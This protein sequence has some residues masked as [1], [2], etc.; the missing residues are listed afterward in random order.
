MKKNGAEI[1]MECLREMGTDTIFGYPGGAVIP[2]YD[3]LY[4]YMDKFK[5]IA[6]SHEQGA[7]HAADGYARSSGKTGVVFATSGPGATN[8]VT[9]IATAYAD[10]VPLIVITGQVNRS[11]I[12]RDSFQEADIT[13][14]TLPVTKHNY[15][16]RRAEDIA[17]VMRE[18]F[19]IA[20]NKRKGPVLIDIPKDVF[21]EE[22]FYENQCHENNKY[23]KN[24]SVS[25]SENDLKACAELINHSKRPV[26]YCGGGITASGASPELME[27]CNKTGIPVVST[28]MGL[29]GFPASHPLSYG[30]V[31]MHG[32]FQA[33]MAVSSSDLILAAGA[34]FSDRVTG[35]TDS[36]AS[37]AKIIQ[38]DIDQAEIGKNKDV[39]LYILG[40]IKDILSKL[41]S[42]TKHANRNGWTKEI[43]SWKISQPYED[44][45]TGVKIIKK[46]NEILG[47]GTIVATDTGQHQMWTAQHWKFEKP[48]TLLSSG[49]FGT[50]GYGLGAAIG[51]SIANP[52]KRVL[53][54]TS[55]GS[56]RMNMNE[57]ATVSRNKLPITILLL[58]N[59]SLGM[60]RQWQNLFCEKRFSG[61]DLGDE[62]DYVKLANAFGITGRRIYCEDELDAAL[63]IAKS[64]STASLI[65]C[66]IDKDEMVLPIV[67]PGMG[68]NNMITK[69]PH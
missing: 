57:L 54:V 25:Y 27:L 31:G 45:M 10:S 39:D 4:K 43:D 61:T 50:M 59:H 64:G 17:S 14:I 55:D 68:I 48:G 19:R 42:Y 22:T 5:Y 34:R 9:G 15:L 16:V 47:S 21:T 26:L 1:V 32:F 51:A 18:A 69:M 58:N 36:F 60:V 11:L 65:E 29:G 37:R 67:P 23:S 6:T 41:N 40:D 38:I 66:V 12:G 30:L 7:V 33:N 24:I 3:A 52:G 20:N 53:L 8:T 49:G 62:V 56:F 35:S 46:A 44:G 28:M 63:D 2:L 13:S